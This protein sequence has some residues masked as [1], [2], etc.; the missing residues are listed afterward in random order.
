MNH[1]RRTIWI[2]AYGIATVVLFLGAVFGNQ[3]QRYIPTMLAGLWMSLGIS[4]L[5]VDWRLPDLPEWSYYPF[6]FTWCALLMWPILLAAIRPGVFKRLWV[7]AVVLLHIAILGLLV[8][9]GYE[10]Y[11]AAIHPGGV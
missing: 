5:A 3:I 4:W 8:F 2:T 1:G 6:T 9:V 10:I 7:K 11:K